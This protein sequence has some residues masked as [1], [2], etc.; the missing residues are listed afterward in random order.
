[1]APNDKTGSG[2]KLI[3]KQLNYSHILIL[4][5]SLLIFSVLFGIVQY[6][7]AERMKSAYFQEQSNRKNAETQI[8]T[9]QSQLNA[10]S[11]EAENLQTKISS[12][13]QQLASVSAQL[14]TAQQELA[15]AKGQIQEQQTQ[16]Y[17]TSREVG[18]VEQRILTLESFVSENAYLPDQIAVQI[19]SKCGNPITKTGDTC[20][21]DTCK[22][23]KD[24]MDCLG[25]K[26]Y[27]DNSTSGDLQS[28]FDIWSFWNSKKGDCDDF[29]FFTSAWLR[30][31]IEQS[32]NVCSSTVAL[33]KP[34]TTSFL[35]FETCGDAL[36]AISVKNESQIF[37]VCG[38]FSSGGCHCEV[39]V[40]SNPSLTPFDNNF[41]ESV[42]LFEPQGGAYQGKS[43]EEFN[44][45]IGWLFANNDFYD[46]D[47]GTNQASSS[48]S[49]LKE[50]LLKSYS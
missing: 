1:M 3:N 29:A 14:N 18:K 19:H 34:K 35:F 22:M 49:S 16:I 21:I 15:Q 32:K 36:S 20:F 38:C 17:E 24:M 27:D 13:E 45:G 5:I 30:Y 46:I 39:G 41:F 2:I 50:D 4:L 42:Y 12:T 31:E 37:D 9:I 26:W 23:G 10:K 48:L 6:A 28:L 33:M 25:F 40:N 11:N 7:N 47:M 8:A 43:N 44:S